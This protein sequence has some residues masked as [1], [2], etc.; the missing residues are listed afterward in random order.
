MLLVVVGHVTLTNV[1]QDPDYPIV[2]AVERIIYSFHMPLF[3]FI[4]GW[5]FYYTCL[6]KN[7]PYKEV[8]KAKF[9]RLG[10]PF[11]AFTVTTMGLKLL[12]APYM[13]RIVDVNEIMNTFLFFSSNPLGEMWFIIVLLVLMSLYPIYKNMVQ[14]SNSAC[15][16]IVVS[17]IIS[18]FPPPCDFFQ[19]RRVAYMLPFFVMGILFCKYGWAERLF[20]FK[21]LFIFTCIFFCCNVFQFLP[22]KMNFIMP[23]AGI[24]FS[25]SLCGNS[26]RYVPGLFESFRDYTFQI[27]LMGIFFQMAIRFIFQRFPSDTLYGIFYLSS[28]VC[29]LYIPVIISRIVMR[30]PKILQNCIGL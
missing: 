21:F 6:R 15:I 14:K 30:G 22:E 26:V 4:S 13:K 9:K 23:W 2:S 18:L 24:F 28:I 16:L 7:K 1:F 3:I 25:L 8:M 11:L 10:I 17:L 29:G 12:F 20:T 19:L 27:F 5:L